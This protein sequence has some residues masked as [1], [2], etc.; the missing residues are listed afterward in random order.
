MKGQCRKK[1]KTQRDSDNDIPNIVAADRLTNKL[2]LCRQGEKEIEGESVL[3]RNAINV[4]I[5]IRSKLNF[6]DRTFQ[7]FWDF[8]VEVGDE[9]GRGGEGRGL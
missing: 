8:G 9:G 1:L 5:K 2:T 6:C 7:T 4:S 3:E